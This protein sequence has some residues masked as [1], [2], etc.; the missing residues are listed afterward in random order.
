MLTENNAA[1]II[2]DPVIFNEIATDNGRLIGHITLNTP[3][4]LNALTLDM[5]DLML[6][7][8]TQWQHDD[9]LVLV[10]IS[11]SVILC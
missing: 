5:I 7:Q 1:E 4:K 2:E 3:A 8:L 10:V 11:G 6:L 9:N